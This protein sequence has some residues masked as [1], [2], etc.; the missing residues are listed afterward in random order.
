MFYRDVE[1]V[2]SVFEGAAAS[3]GAIRRLLRF[4][5]AIVLWDIGLTNWRLRQKI[6]NFLLPKIDQLFVLGTNQVEYIEKTYAPCEAITPIGHYVDTDFYSPAPLQMSGYV[7]SV[8]EDV[9][10]D[11]STLMEA[12]KDIDRN[13]IVKAGNPKIEAKSANVKIVRERLSYADLRDLYAGSSIVVL[14]SFKTDNASG[15][16]TILE[17]CA[18]GRPMVVAD[19]PG[20]Y[21]FIIPGE[22]CLVVPVQDS[23]AM[24]NA[25]ERLIADP[26]LC[27]K[28]ATK[29]RRF[30]EEKFSTSA[31]AKQ[32]AH[33]LRTV[34]ASNKR[35][36]N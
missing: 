28:L 18:S 15:V 34:D 19:N 2:V 12:V 16:S 9:G 25:I 27:T 5:P 26:E 13:V 17:A 36:R 29:A 1:V 20:I 33:H 10:R 32:F 23:N 11:F 7:L 21:D 6:I 24:K 22:T 8:G 4:E 14:L 30:V 3:L 31:F 35:L